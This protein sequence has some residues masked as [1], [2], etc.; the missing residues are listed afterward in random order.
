MLFDKCLA[1]SSKMSHHL[2]RLA[3]SF[4]NFFSIL[5]LKHENQVF[6]IS[7][8][9]A[10]T[11]CFKLP[12]NLMMV[13]YVSSDEQL[14][15]LL[16]K[17]NIVVLKRYSTFAIIAIL[18]VMLLMNFV[19]LIISFTQFVL[20]NKIKCFMNKVAENPLTS[21]YAR[22]FQNICVRDTAVLITVSTVSLIVQFIDSYKISFLNFV[23]SMILFYGHVMIVCLLSFIKNFEN[24]IVASIKQLKS[25]IKENYHLINASENEKQSEF[26][27]K[28]QRI[29][30]L[31]LQFDT[32]LGLQLTIL[33]VYLTSMLVFCVR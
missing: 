9:T 12:L 29:C 8:F 32:S 15:N 11:N 31:M 10:N 30:D 18:I 16:F 17:K 6:T 2:Q 7:T 33:A 3:L 25:D 1:V 13:L 27:R 26:I 14:R 28:H 20:R 4:Y 22:K 23:F 21:T 24:F 5:C 19:M